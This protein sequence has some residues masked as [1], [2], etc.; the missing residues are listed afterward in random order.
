MV[1]RPARSTRVR[2]TG[3][4][5]QAEIGRERPVGRCGAMRRESA[6]H[7]DH[8][9]ERRYAYAPVHQQ[10]GPRD[11]LEQVVGAF[12]G[13]VHADASVYRIDRVG[14]NG[15]ERLTVAGAIGALESG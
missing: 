5:T 6:T 7:V 14:G 11:E 1:P 15:H 3:G 2:A 4:D 13:K 12:G 10:L 9:D 8:Q